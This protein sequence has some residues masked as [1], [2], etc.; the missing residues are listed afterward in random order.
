ML[1]LESVAARADSYSEPAATSSLRTEAVVP[2]LA[3]VV[4]AASRTD[5][6]NQ[7]RPDRLAV[8]IGPL[9]PADALPLLVP[10]WRA[11]ARPALT[12]ATIIS[13]SNSPNTASMP[14]MARPAGVVVSRLGM[15]VK[16]DVRLADGLQDLGEM[17]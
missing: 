15:D 4:C 13:R 5:A 11:R 1:I 7:G 17:L 3:P 16:A 14:N 12:R 10:D 2:T 8:V 9:R 6:L